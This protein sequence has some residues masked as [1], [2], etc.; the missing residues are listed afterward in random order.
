VRQEDIKKMKMN[1]TMID[2]EAEIVSILTLHA[3]KDLTPSSEEDNTSLTGR[4][5]QKKQIPRPGRRGKEHSMGG[6]YGIGGNSLRT[7]SKYLLLKIKA[8]QGHVG[9]EK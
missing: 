4:P 6:G 8:A 5:S 9:L 3:M 1:R 7:P 2:G